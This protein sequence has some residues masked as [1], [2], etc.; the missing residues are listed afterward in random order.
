MIFLHAPAIFPIAFGFFDLLLLIG[1]VQLWCGTSRVVIDA[2]HVRV[3]SGLL[4]GGKWREFP[5]SQILDI[6]ALITA[7]QGGASGT[8]YYDIRLLQ[9]EHQNITLGRT[10]KDKDEAEWLVNEMKKALQLRAAAAAASN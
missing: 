9:T 3:Q 10:I 1:A 6:Q 2:T 8:P 7:Q 4:G 5:K